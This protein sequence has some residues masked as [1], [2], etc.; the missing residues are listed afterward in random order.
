MQLKNKLYLILIPILIIILLIVRHRRPSL[1]LDSGPLLVMGTYANI[2]VRCSDEQTG[3]TAMRQAMTALEEVDRCF[4]VYREDS[5]LSTVN[6]LGAAGWVP[7]SLQT[8]HVLSLAKLYYH[9]TSGAFD[10][11]VSPLIHV[12]KQAEKNDKLPTINEIEQAAQMTDSD[13]IQLSEPGL[14]HAVRLAKPGVEIVANALA[15]GWAVDHALNAMRL[16]GVWGAMIDIGGEIACFSNDPQTGPWTIGVQ[17]PFV[18]NYASSQ[19]IASEVITLTNGSVATSGNYRRY[20]TIN[21][22]HYSHIIDPRTGRPADKLPSVTVT[23]PRTIDAD[24]LATAISVLGVTDG[25]TLI[26]SLDGIECLLIDGTP[27]KPIFHRSTGWPTAK[28]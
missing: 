7:V 14:P 11:T 12:W 24:A 22:E 6:R 27:E 8:W 25:L 4:N 21:S 15:K 5:E 23:A 10:I 20:V 3:Q 28:P 1:E 17:N 16:P 19:I 2:K 26:E 9:L 13:Y 18:S